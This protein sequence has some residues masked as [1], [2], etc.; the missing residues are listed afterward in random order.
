VLSYGQG[1]W[2][3]NWVFGDGAGINFSD[4]ANPT[5]FTTECNNFEPTAS[6]SDS[7]GNLL[8]YIANT[9]DHYEN[10]FWKILDA[11]NNLIEN[12]DSIFVAWSATNGAI[13]LDD[14]KEKGSYYLI[15]ICDSIFYDY[16]LLYS[17]I[18]THSDGTFYLT[19]KNQIL[20][21]DS[22]AERI[23]CIKHANGKDWWII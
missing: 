14:P 12:G 10:K 20:F 21:S 15:Q 16:Q 17:K 13:I 3:A 5:T 22:I 8:F 18:K 19:V 9:E 4:T 6:I 2:D 11:N 1:K 23:S 7:L